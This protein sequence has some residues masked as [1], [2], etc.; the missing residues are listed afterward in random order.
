MLVKVRDTSAFN[1][2]GSCGNRVIFL[3][4]YLKDFGNE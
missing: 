3:K 4:K 2:S 1:Y